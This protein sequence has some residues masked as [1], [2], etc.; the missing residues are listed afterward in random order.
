[1][2]SNDASNRTT[3]P[4]THTGTLSFLKLYKNLLIILIVL[5]AILVVLMLVVIALKETDHG[6]GNSCR[7]A[8][9]TP[10]KTKSFTVHDGI[11]TA[12]VRSEAYLEIYANENRS[13]EAGFLELELD[14]I[15][16]TME[17][18]KMTMY[19]KG[20]AD[21]AMSIYQ[22]S[23]ETKA[24]GDYIWY[25]KFNGKELLLE[26]NFVWNWPN[27]MRYSCLHTRTI[28]CFFSHD[29]SVLAGQVV[30]KN[31]EIELNGSLEFI[32]RNKFSKQA[33]VYSC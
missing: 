24:R 28:P 25:F 22:G 15:E 14:R 7:L 1:M 2:D 26:P 21:L 8:K 32:S 17:N 10:K 12:L 18:R 5:V 6:H 20:C 23:Q 29:D 31:L 30:F 16:L 11:K 9:S 13:I 33:Y 4:A 27:D 3:H 19:H